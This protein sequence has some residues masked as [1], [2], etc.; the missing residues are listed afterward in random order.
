MSK[1]LEKI[2]GLSIERMK[3]REKLISVETEM[4]LVSVELSKELPSAAENV[5]E[6]KETGTNI[7]ETKPDS[8]EKPR[9][10][11]P[12]RAAGVAGPTVAA[13][14]SPMPGHVSVDPKAPTVDGNALESESDGP[15]PL[16]EMACSAIDQ[17]A[18][19]E[20]M[21]GG[22][23]LNAL[24]QAGV[25]GDPNSDSVPSDV[26][27]KGK[28]ELK[29]ALDLLVAHGIVQKEGEGKSSKYARILN[30]ETTSEGDEPGSIVPIL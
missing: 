7:S 18:L 24:L 16:T 25:I 17:M 12:K 10:G 19:G 22:E 26:L 1:A 5:S 9:R 11:R 30:V 21:S 8:T 20:L 6:S 29:A 13:D 23:I 28:G 15:G 3:L 27:A 14:G 4:I 2:T